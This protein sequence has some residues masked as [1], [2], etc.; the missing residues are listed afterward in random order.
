MQVPQSLK[1]PDRLMTIAGFIRAGSS[2]A[3]IGTDHG[4]LPVY[5]AVNGLAQRITASDI[6]AGSLDSARR[7]AVA[8]GVAGAITFVNAPG[9]DGVNETDTDTIVIAGLG[10]ETIA[11]IL[12]HA[13][14]VKKNG[15]SLILQPQSKIE[16]L[17][18]WLRESAFII[19][20]AKLALDNGRYYVVMLV[21]G[22]EPDSILEPELELL[23]RLMHGRD[24][25][26]ADYIDDLIRRTRRALDG[27]KTGSAPDVLRT[28]LKLS[29]YIGLKEANEKWES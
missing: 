4:L 13:P 15:V 23:A 2:V 8:Y 21:T 5:L 14:W 27:M 11:D 6:S 1:L 24:P 7:S 28:A 17:C 18:R 3:D 26:F 20:G 9:L 19:R 10:G 29:V 12:R 25:L 22:G 16:E